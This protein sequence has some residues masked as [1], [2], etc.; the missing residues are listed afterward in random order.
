LEP[1]GD[2]INIHLEVTGPAIQLE[3]YDPSITKQGKSRELVFQWPG[4][5]AVD[6]FRVELQQPFDASQMVTEPVLG[7]FPKISNNLTYHVGNFGPFQAG[8]TFTL[9]VNYQKQTDDLSVSAMPVQ[10]SAPVDENTAGRVSL[11]TYMPWLAAGAGLLLVAGGLYYYFRGQPRPK[12]VRRRRDAPAESTEG[13][14]YCPQ[15]GTRARPGDR[16]CR[17]CGTRMRPGSEE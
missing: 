16:F 12:Q 9:K 7:D 17:T 5:Y 3:Y 4:D 8:E 1:A 10:S 14:K 11:Q 15:C 6:S 13:P 2:W